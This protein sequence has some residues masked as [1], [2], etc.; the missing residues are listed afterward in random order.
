M[1]FS[2]QEEEGVRRPVDTLEPHPFSV[3]SPSVIAN[4]LRSLCAAVEEESF[5]ADQ[6]NHAGE[7]TKQ[8]ETIF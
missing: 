2:L 5:T 6:G 1:L 3:V 7:A 4:R 8:H